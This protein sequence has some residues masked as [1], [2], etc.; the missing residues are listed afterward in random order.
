MCVSQIIRSGEPGPLRA[1]ARARQKAS[2]QVE[3]PKLNYGFYV[4]ARKFS[5]ARTDKAGQTGW[6]FIH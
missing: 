3:G 2:G 1:P 5:N 4:N 6:R